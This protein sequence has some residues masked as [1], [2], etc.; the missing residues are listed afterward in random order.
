MREVLE[1]VTKSLETSYFFQ[2][3]FPLTVLLV[4]PAFV[5]LAR[6]YWQALAGLVSMVLESLGLSL[7]WRR[8]S[9]VFESSGLSAS[10]EK[11]TK[12]TGAVRTRAEQ[13]LAN[14][15]ALHGRKSHPKL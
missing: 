14:G 11:K 2:Q 12:K 8:K 13:V 15:S 9:Y 5:L 6:S 7:P 10:E 3:I 1:S 4:T